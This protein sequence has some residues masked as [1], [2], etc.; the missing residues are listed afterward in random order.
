MDSFMPHGVSRNRWCRRGWVAL[1]ALAW[2]GVLHATTLQS[3]QTTQSAEGL[4]LSAA[5][6]VNLTAQ[7]QQALERG[8]PLY[9]VHQVQVVQ[10][11]W[12]WRD[13]V[14]SDHKRRLRLAQQAL[15]RQWRVAVLDEPTGTADGG[16]GQTLSFTVPS[17]SAALA[18]IGKVSQ[19]LVLPLPEW[20]EVGEAP[21]LVYRFYLDTSELP[22]PFQIG[23]GSSAEWSVRLEAVRPLSLRA[24]TPTEVAR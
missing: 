13:R 10:P 14:V 21:R 9:F 20:P 1:L 6:Q 17:V 18:L 19:W 22:G 7:V 4:R 3:I 8:V 15:T 16:S 2:A 12:W 23:Q 24:R 5:V 11:R